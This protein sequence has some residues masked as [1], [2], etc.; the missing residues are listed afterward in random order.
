MYIDP[1]SGGLIF[2]VLIV[3]FGVFSASVLL[4]SSK[5]KMGI[6]KLRRSMRKQGGDSDAIEENPDIEQ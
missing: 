1:N 3:L 2:Q 5:I 4:F 6:A